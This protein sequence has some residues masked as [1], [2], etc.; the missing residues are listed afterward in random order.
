MAH[1]DMDVINGI[2]VNG[3]PSQMLSGH[4]ASPRIDTV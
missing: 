1:G 2:R 3:S 4:G